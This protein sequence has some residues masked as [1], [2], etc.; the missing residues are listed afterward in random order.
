MD[1]GVRKI[2]DYDEKEIPLYENRE[3]HSRDLEL[4]ESI[5]KMKLDIESPETSSKPPTPAIVHDTIACTPENKPEN[6][7]DD[8]S[9]SG[10]L[11][12][13]PV[14]KCFAP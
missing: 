14:R 10:S 5:W 1:D 9:S 7:Q 6:K 4:V 11:A 2:Y 3:G 13:P 8:V 12:T